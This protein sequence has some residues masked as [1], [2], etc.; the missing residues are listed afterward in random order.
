MPWNQWQLSSGMGGS[1]ALE[2]VAGLAWNTQFNTAI[3]RQGAPHHLSSDNDP[4]FRYHRWHANL[5]IPG[6]EEIESIPYTPVSHPFV[7]RL[8]GTIRREHLDRAFFWSAQDLERKPGGLLRYYNNSRVHQSLDGSVP[9]EVSGGHQP[10]PARLSHYSW[11]S[12]CNGL[13]QTPVAA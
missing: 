6:A 10:L 3:S 4:V 9:A 7:E 2:S 11:I 8:I 13:F 5:R 12:D 1:L